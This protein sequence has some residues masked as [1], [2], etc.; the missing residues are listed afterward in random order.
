[1][2]FAA[3]V[4]ERWSPREYT[5]R[6]VERELLEQVFEAVHWAQSSFNEQPWRYVIA[7]RDHPHREQ[8]ESYLTEGNAFAKEAWVLGVSFTKKTFT[9]IP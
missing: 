9:S 7:T 4:Q 1:M 6:E 2:D 8:L 3:L 5:R